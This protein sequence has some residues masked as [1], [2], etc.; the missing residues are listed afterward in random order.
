MGREN[1]PHV[2]EPFLYS[3]LDPVQFV[4]YIYRHMSENINSRKD[5]G[6]GLL[7]Q[8]QPLIEMEEPFIPLN[9]VQ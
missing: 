9:L 3:R 4:Q 8:V 5:T 6:T 1:R 2:P 7:S